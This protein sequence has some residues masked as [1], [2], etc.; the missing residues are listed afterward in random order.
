MNN[1]QPGGGGQDAAVLAALDV[2]AQIEARAGENV[3]VALGEHFQIGG[4]L[5]EQVGQGLPGVVALLDLDRVVGQAGM[6]GCT[7]GV[8]RFIQ[9]A[10]GR[11]LRG[12][13]FGIVRVAG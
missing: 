7:V 8:E 4:Q 3:R 13:R 11:D 10:Q 9:P 5:R 2:V 6:I 12:P 1:A